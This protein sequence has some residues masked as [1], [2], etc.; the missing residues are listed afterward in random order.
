MLLVLRDHKV[1]R[2][3]LEQKGQ[4]DLLVLTVVMALT[5]LTVLTVLMELRVRGV[6]KVNLEQK[7]QGGLLGQMELMVLLEPR[8]HRDPLVQME[9]MEATVVM[10]LMEHR[11]MI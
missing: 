11:H 9:L 10:V 1:H 6:H 3:S 4:E 2:G 5:V 8:G 7:V